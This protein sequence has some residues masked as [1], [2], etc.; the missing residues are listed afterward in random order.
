MTSISGLL[1]GM[2]FRATRATSNPFLANPIEALTHWNC[3]LSRGTDILEFTISL[4]SEAAPPAETA[5]GLLLADLITVHDGEAFDDWAAGLNISIGDD[6]HE[7]FMIAYD[8]IKAHHEA[9]TSTFGQS[10]MDRA[11]A[12]MADKAPTMA[13]D[14]EATM[15]PVDATTSTSPG[16]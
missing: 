16:L 4:Q 12:F 6:R 7:A 10:W 8:A 3:Q 1:D 13:P 2:D 5:V 11:A 15:V 14:H 9:V